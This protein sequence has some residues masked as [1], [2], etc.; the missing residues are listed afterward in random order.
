MKGTTNQVEMMGMG[1]RQTRDQ[2]LAPPFTDAVAMGRPLAL[3]DSEFLVEDGD[4][5]QCNT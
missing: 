2:I 5:A 3:A 1:D 4:D